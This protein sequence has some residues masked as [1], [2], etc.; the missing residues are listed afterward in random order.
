MKAKEHARLMVKLE[1]E[2]GQFWKEGRA[3][4][5]RCSTINKAWLELYGQQSGGFYSFWEGWL[6][7]K[8]EKNQ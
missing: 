5:S 4:A 2:E 7:G 1:S 8:K 3:A 6:Y